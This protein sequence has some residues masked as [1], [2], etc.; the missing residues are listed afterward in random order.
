[1][2]TI[3]FGILAF[4][5]KVIDTIGPIDLLFSA[6]RIA[7]QFNREYGPVSDELI[8]QAPQFTFH[9]IGVTRDPIQL[10]TGNLTIIPTTTV[11]ECP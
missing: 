11:D 2:A 5:Y 10:G 8:S 9:H 6:N 3:Q 4:A 7:F 1:M